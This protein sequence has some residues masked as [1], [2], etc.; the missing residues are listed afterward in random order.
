M[1][2]SADVAVLIPWRPG[3]PHREAALRWVLAYYAEKYPRW[4][5]ILGASPDGPF[6]RSA[7][8]LDALRSTDRSVLLVA[9]GDVFCDPLMAVEATTGSGWAVPH[10]LIHRLS[11][12]SS[13]KVLTGA[14]WRG[15][16]LSADN[17]QDRRPYRGNETG[18]MYAI[19]RDVLMEVPPD[20]RFVGWG[21]EDE[22]HG[23]ALRTLVG[24]PWRGTEDLVHLWHPPQERLT[25]RV[26]SRENMAVLRQYRQ[27]NHRPSRMRLVVEES[28]QLAAE[29]R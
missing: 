19:R 13:G 24:K 8:T 20:V 6:N 3:C 17:E 11:P 29:L 16:P 5:V 15:L 28:R 14:D 25:R 26:G 18:T 7:A 4:Q 12:E 9:D 10:K 23:M 1:A 22:A 21:S 27:A 2:V